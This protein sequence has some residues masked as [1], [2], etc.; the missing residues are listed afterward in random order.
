MRILNSHFCWFFNL[1]RNEINV[2]WR[3]WEHALSFGIWWQCTWKSNSGS[4]QMQDAAR[5]WILLLSC[6]SENCIKSLAS[7]AEVGVFLRVQV[8]GWSGTWCRNLIFWFYF[9]SSGNENKCSLEEV[10]VYNSIWNTNCNTYGG[11]TLAAC[12]CKMRFSLQ[13]MFQFHFEPCE[14]DG[15]MNEF[16]V[17]YCT[18]QFG[19]GI[20]FCGLAFVLAWHPLLGGSGKGLQI[21]I[22]RLQFPNFHQIQHIEHTKW[23]NE[24]TSAD[25]QALIPQSMSWWQLTNNVHPLNLRDRGECFAPHLCIWSWNAECHKCD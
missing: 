19:R 6:F 15:E 13:I 2:I 20:G 8:S 24:P 17:T 16:D 5:L 22:S 21:R 9:D 3:Q 7:D 4:L 23:E 11:L 14:N 25:H 10:T 1:A 12:R 18:E